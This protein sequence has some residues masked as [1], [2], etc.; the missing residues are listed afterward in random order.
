MTM[1]HPVSGGRKVRVA[2]ACLACLTLVLSASGCLDIYGARDVF[3]K[4]PAPGKPVYKDRSKFS[5]AHNFETKITDPSSW[6]YAATCRT[7]VK[8]NTEWLKVVIQVTLMDLPANFSQ[9]PYK[10]PERYVRVE[11]KMADGSQW[12]DS[13]YM[14]TAQETV[15]A[16]N[17]IDG[18]WSVYVEATGV[19][20]AQLGYQDN[21]KVFL[22]V[23]EPV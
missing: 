20:V 13:R 15:V 19:G 17:P 5:L 1:K 8:K 7:M 21:F 11:V 10:I 23:R 12:V 3:G 4:K 6:N 14:A 18:P 16:T 9:L 2:L 22:S